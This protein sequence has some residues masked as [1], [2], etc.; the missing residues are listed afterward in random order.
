VSEPLRDPGAAFERTQLAWQRY[1]LGLAVVGVLCLRSGLVGQHTVLGFT[2]AFVLGGLAALLQ[3][4]GPRLTPH[5]AVRLATA[6]SLIAAVGA[7][8]LGLA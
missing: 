5:R 1:A 7:V 6:A 3:I 8:V 2:L 4:L